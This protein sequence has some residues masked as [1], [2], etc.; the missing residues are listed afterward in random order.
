[1]ASPLPGNLLDVPKKFP[2]HKSAL[3]GSI[4]LSDL[5]TACT[6]HSILFTD[7]AMAPSPYLLK[8]GYWRVDPGNFLIGRLSGCYPHK[9]L[10]STTG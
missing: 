5:R 7:K 4:S 8:A 3:Y 6:S 1:M 9:Y 2:K 10:S